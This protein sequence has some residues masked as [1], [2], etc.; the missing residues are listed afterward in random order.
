MNESLD[1]RNRILKMRESNNVVLDQ[2]KS[3]IK[4]PE[5]SNENPPQKTQNNVISREVN[6]ETK[7]EKEISPLEN[8]KIENSNI[9][10]VR[11]PIKQKS[12]DLPYG[13][14]AQ[15]R[16]IAKKFNEAVEVI[17]EL[18]QKVE[19]LERNVSQN[20]N[21]QKNKVK[22]SSLLRLK[23]L[24]FILLIPIILLGFFTIPFDFLLIKSITRRPFISFF[25]QL[26]TKNF[27]DYSRRIFFI[28]SDFVLIKR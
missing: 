25:T 17:L 19:K 8:K 28:R 2:A 4:T 12:D 6:F 21:I 9:K 7:L 15:F 11:N 1:L 16:M 26:L 10:N 3:E 5:A 14:E 20:K 24:V 13:N 22:S 18:S 27:I 23:I